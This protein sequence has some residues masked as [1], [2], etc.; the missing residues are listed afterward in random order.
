MSFPAFFYWRGMRQK[1]YAFGTSL[2]NAYDNMLCTI[3]S[4]YDVFINDLDTGTEYALNDFADNTK[5]VRAV[6]S[7]ESGKALQRQIDYGA[8]QSL[9]LLNLASANSLPGMV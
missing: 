8:E 5:L 7:L 3:C 1:A 2:L 9:T 6:D 4:M